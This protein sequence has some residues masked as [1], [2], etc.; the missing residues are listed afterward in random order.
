MSKS[1]RSATDVFVKGDINQSQQ[2]VYL[3]FLYFKALYCNENYRDY[4]THKNEGG[5]KQVEK[6]E[7]EYEGINYI[8]SLFGDLSKYR[9]ATDNKDIIITFAEWYKVEGSRFHPISILKY[10][11]VPA[12]KPIKPK[13]GTVY[14]TAPPKSDV[15]FVESKFDEN[16]NK[17]L[18]QLREVFK[19]YWLPLST[20]DYYK[21]D[22]LKP[23]AKRLDVYVWRKIGGL[24]AEESIFKAYESGDSHWDELKG[25]LDE[26]SKDVGANYKELSNDDL[27]NLRSEF[28][29]SLREAKKVIANTIIGRFPS[30]S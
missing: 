28:S 1:Q 17:T 23:T 5:S 13:A 12:D 29:T 30:K 8:A 15:N 7:A 11:V 20:T 25:K 19:K 18:K 10:K 2:A 14:F 6:L 4:W 16:L 24:S 9:K 22:K 27:Q 21:T 26:L 3:I